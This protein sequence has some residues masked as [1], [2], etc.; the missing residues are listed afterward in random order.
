M[1]SVA[2]GLQGIFELGRHIPVNMRGMNGTENQPSVVK[3]AGAELHALAQK[4]GSQ[5]GGDP[6]IRARTASR[7]NG[8]AAIPQTTALEFASR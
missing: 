8:R 4:L 3:A 1:S 6:L 7:A 2:T 5:R